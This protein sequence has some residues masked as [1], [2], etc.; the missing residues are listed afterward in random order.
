V[1]G[2]GRGEDG[3][4]K[5]FVLEQAVEVAARLHHVRLCKG[6]K[7]KDCDGFIF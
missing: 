3:H 5:P 2:G 1:E 6:G 4:F 7:N